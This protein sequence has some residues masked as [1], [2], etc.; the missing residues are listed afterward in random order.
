[1]NRP[2]HEDLLG[3]VRHVTKGGAEATEDIWADVKAFIDVDPAAALDLFSQILRMVGS[4]LEVSIVAADYLEPLLTRHG[5][6][7]FDEVT[8]RMSDEKFRTA[9]TSVM[10]AHDEQPRL[11]HVLDRLN[12]TTS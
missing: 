1:M 6:D 8:S 11:R 3:Y 4:S 2:T 5:D 10:I 9:L 12:A 7:L